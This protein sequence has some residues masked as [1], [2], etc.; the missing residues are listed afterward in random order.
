MLEQDIGHSVIKTDNLRKF[1][2]RRRWQRCGQAIR[3]MQ[4]MSSRE[5]EIIF[6]C[7]DSYFIPGLMSK[8]RSTEGENLPAVSPNTSKK[9]SENGFCNPQSISQNGAQ[10]SNLFEQRLKEEFGGHQRIFRS[11]F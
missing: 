3:A 6:Y 10:C 9:I 2:A 1:L 5:R 11:I 4:R 8:S 7:R